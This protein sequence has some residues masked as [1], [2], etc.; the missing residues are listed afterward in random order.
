M[1]ARKQ[2]ML[3]TVSTRVIPF[4]IRCSEVVSNTVTNLRISSKAQ[5]FVS[6]EQQAAFKIKNTDRFT[7]TG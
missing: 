4:V 5:N 3:M 7:R 6:S 1:T 2:S